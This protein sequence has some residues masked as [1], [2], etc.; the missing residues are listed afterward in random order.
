MFKEQAPIALPRL[1]FG[2]WCSVLILSFELCS[3]SFAAQA[4][5]PTL[6]HFY[7]VAVQVGTTNTLAAVGKF[8]PWP[9]KAWLDAPG[10]ELKAA[11]NSGQFAVEI[12]SNALIGPH[13]VRL[14]NEQGAS[15][16]RF[17]VVTSAPQLEEVESNDDFMKPQALDHFPV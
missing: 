4:A 6:D 14:F 1:R 5:A 16:P 7:P 13:L 10:I 3:L 2:N 12:T 15:K 11:T 8:D 17:L 9:P